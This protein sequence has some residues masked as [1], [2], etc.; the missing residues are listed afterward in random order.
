MLFHSLEPA[1]LQ[2]VKASKGALSLHCGV[3]VVHTIKPVIDIISDS[4]I[5]IYQWIHQRQQCLQKGLGDSWYIPSSE[6]DALRALPESCWAPWASL[7]SLAPC[8]IAFDEQHCSD[9]SGFYIER[10]AKKKPCETQECWEFIRSSSRSWFYLISSIFILISL[11]CV[12]FLIYIHLCKL[13]WSTGMYSCGR[14]R[15][16]KG[17][18]QDWWLRAAEIFEQCEVLGFRLDLLHSSKKLLLDKFS[19][20]RK[21]P[22]LSGQVGFIL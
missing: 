18:T 21:I 20:C 17:I 19:S 2:M 14:R 11:R 6:A 22:L 9:R 5:H 16:S 8:G 13:F 10:C 7:H 4:A 3:A 12:P 15:G 1:Q